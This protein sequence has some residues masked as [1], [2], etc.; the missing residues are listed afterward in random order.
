M[1]EI[2]PIFIM[3]PLAGESARS[4]ASLAGRAETAPAVESRPTV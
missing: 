4:A 1:I 2:P 3:S